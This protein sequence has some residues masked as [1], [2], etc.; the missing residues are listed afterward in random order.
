MSP[1]SWAIDSAPMC[2]YSLV[3]SQVQPGSPK[4]E[5]WRVWKKV[6][7]GLLAHSSSGRLGS[8]GISVAFVYLRHSTKVSS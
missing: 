8:P 4:H 1:M 5:G 7:M 2:L 6:R 3:F